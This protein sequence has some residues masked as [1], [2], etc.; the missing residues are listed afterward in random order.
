MVKI[1]EINKEIYINDDCRQR[2][3][4]TIRHYSNRNKPGYNVYIY[5]NDEE[6]T[7]I[8]SLILSLEIIVFRLKGIK[9]IS[10]KPIRI[11]SS[12]K[13]IKNVI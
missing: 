12:L 1:N 8:Y 10:R 4:T 9:F 7:N 5:E 2:D 6:M 11:F 13:I 3:R